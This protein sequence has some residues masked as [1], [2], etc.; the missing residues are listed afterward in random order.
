[1]KSYPQSFLTQK[2]EVRLVRPLLLLS[3]HSVP[4]RGLVTSEKNFVLMTRNT[5]GEKDHP[6][7]WTVLLTLKRKKVCLARGEI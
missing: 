2:G 3:R 4:Q 6:L 7:Y 5:T 1:M